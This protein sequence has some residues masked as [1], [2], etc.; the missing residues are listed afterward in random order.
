MKYP[1]VSKQQTVFNFSQLRHGVIKMIE[2]FNNNTEVARE[3]RKTIIEQL[4][5][6]YASISALYGE[7]CH[8][9]RRKYLLKLINQHKEQT[10]IYENLISLSDDELL[11]KFKDCWGVL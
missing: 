10:E 6:E 9:L 7:Y 11:T 1:G 5:I 2:V 3:M 8:D 4:S